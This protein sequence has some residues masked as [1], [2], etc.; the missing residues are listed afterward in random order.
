MTSQT[1]DGAKIV[2]VVPRYE[3]TYQQRIIATTNTSGRCAPRTVTVIKAT[4]RHSSITP[5]FSHNV[6]SFRYRAAPAEQMV[7]LLVTVKRPTV[8]KWPDRW[9]KS[10]DH[11]AF[12]V[13]WALE[14]IQGRNAVLDLVQ[15]KGKQLIFPVVA[16]L[17]TA[18]KANAIAM[19]AAVHVKSRGAWIWSLPSSES[20]HQYNNSRHNRS[21]AGVPRRAGQRQTR[22]AQPQQ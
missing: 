11:S 3:A 13:V 2:R 16:T 1:N 6:Q 5:E 4:G 15:L 7:A 14:D 12:V 21:S 8:M 9:W 18:I 17:C 22:N 10:A 20:R 19:G